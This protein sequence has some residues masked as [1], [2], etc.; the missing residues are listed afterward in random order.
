M[1]LA[2]I[3][4]ALGLKRAAHLLRRATFG[5][6]KQQID[7][8]AALT[9]TQA[10]MQ[11]FGQTLPDP[12]LPI[13]P[14]TGQEWVTTGTTDANS[15]GSDLNQYLLSW[16][17]GQMMNPSLAYSARE[18]IVLFLHTH[19]TMIMEKVSD[20][21]ALYFQ[22]ALFRLFALDANAGDPEV[23]FKT[24]TVKVSVDNAM[25]QL[26]DG[27]LNV[28]GSFNENYAR[29]LLELYSIGRGLE[30]NPPA[31]SGEDGD[32]GV[33]R[34]TDVQTAARILTG[35][36]YDEDF[37]NIDPDTGLPRGRV[38]GSPT[39]ASAHDNDTT[40]PKQFSDR[41]TSALFPGNTIIP[42]PL[43]MPGGNPTEE[44]ALDEISKL[45]DI[46]YEQ[47]E[48]A[49]NICR[50]IYR[51]YLW[52]P[53]TSEEA[54]VVEGIVD[55]MVAL[56]I[57]P[58]NNFRIQ[59]VIE[60]LLRSQ[61]FYESAGGVTDDSFGGLIKSPIDLVV[62]TLRFFNIQ[63]PDLA[64]Q[65]EQ[66]YE[67]TGEILGHIVNQGMNFYNPYD[68]AGYEAYHQYPVYHR[69]W[70]TTNS[71]SKRYD[72]IRMLIDAQGTM[73]FNVNTYEYVRDNFAAVAADSEA[74]LIALATYLLPHHDALTFD[75]LADDTS[76]LTAPRLTYF[77]NRFLT[78]V[79]M[80]PEAY[81]TDTWNQGTDIGELREWLNRLFGALLQSPEYQLS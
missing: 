47:P 7:S 20:S 36:E 45:V 24:L 40:E 56:F 1:P 53:H 10:T 41:F 79:S 31:T 32:Y 22:N 80:N 67:A 59:P 77:K 39:N 50:K 63:I 18:K 48:T 33:Y 28:K 73:G 34:E 44:S 5:A 54:M 23:N 78:D 30:A 43:L 37:T 71:L 55:Q 25:L 4:G 57:S 70:I 68:V 72:F 75:E 76:S 2:E 81:W 64:S 14:K 16:F 74:L 3:S 9:P 15:E 46:I 66:Y 69:Y 8:F 51:F 61:H 6:T 12:V 21:R 19:F 42:D 52:A 65:P 27:T 11:L 17:I 60:N 62:G 49:R 13:D 26:L 29:E 58:A 38:K 35:W